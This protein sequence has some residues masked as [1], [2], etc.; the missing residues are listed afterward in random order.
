[1]SEML[2]PNGI[3]AISPPQH[4]FMRGK[5]NEVVK[6]KRRYSRKELV[7]QLVSNGLTIQKNTS[8]VFT[9]FP[10][11]FLSSLP[12]RKL[13]KSNLDEVELGQRVKF[14]TTSNRVLDF[15][16]WIDEALIPLGFSLPFREKL[17]VVAK[18]LIEFFA[19]PP[20]ITLS[21]Y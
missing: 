4:M 3:L 18:K 14:S 20:T 7:S 5:L 21:T 12:D 13:D 19:P 2:N 10:L 9:L 1:M 8:F 17:L 6:H 16:M 11:I 15:F